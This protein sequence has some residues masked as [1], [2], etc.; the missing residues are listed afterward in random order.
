M[1][2]FLILFGISLF[3]SVVFFILNIIFIDDIFSLLCFIFICVSFIFCIL[4]LNS[5]PNGHV[6]W[7]LDHYDYCPQ[8]GV[9]MRDVIVCDCGNVISE[10]IFGRFDSYCSEC[11]SLLK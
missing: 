8:C 1:N 4:F 3:L 2:I 11:G 9:R 10:D 7:C 5:C 6:D